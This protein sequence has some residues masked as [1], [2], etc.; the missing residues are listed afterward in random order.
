M[1]LRP[2]F[3]FCLERE[4]VRVKK[5][6]GAE[7]PWT[8]DPIIHK[9]FFCNIYREDDKV[10]RWFRE[11]VRDVVA[12]DALKSLVACTAMRWFN[13]TESGELLKDLMIEGWDP[14]EAFRRLARERAY[15]F[16]VFSP[17]YIISSPYGDPKIEWALKCITAM[18]TEGEDILKYAVNQEQLHLRMMRMSGHGGFMA[19]E[20]IT[21][22]R[23]TCVLR[24]A[25]DIMTWTNPGPGCAR[26]LG[27]ITHNDNHVYNRGS[28]TDRAT[29]LRYMLE[30]RD[31]S[32]AEAFK[33][34]W[35]MREVEH[36]LCEFD[37]YR[38]YQTGSRPKRRYP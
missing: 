1:N 25:P 34:Q 14:A 29:M 8:D 9:S 38:R 33:R 6:A 18:A 2:F 27:W 11:N 19:Y 37:K 22:L 13:R 21:D 4:R 12:E 26:G 32:D 28:A 30:I 35:E 36:T 7:R 16:P 24:N 10:T 15:G 31:R 23:W 20:I 3:D 5:E 17:A